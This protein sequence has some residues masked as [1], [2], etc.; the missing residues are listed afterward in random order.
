MAAPRKTK[1]YLLALG[2]VLVLVITFGYIFYRLQNNT[3]LNLTAFFEGI[4]SKGAL[5]SYYFLIFFLLATFNW[6][7]EVLKWKSLA[8]TLEKL[9]FK[10]ALKQTLA[11]L[12]VS[13]AT[14]NRIG[15]YGAKALFFHREKRKKVLLLNFYSNGIQLLTTVIF[16]VLGLFH[17]LLN[18]N[19]LYSSTALIYL[20]IGVSIFLIVMY[21]F[22][23]KELLMKGFSISNVF[24]FFKRFPNS[25]KANVVLFSICR[26]LIFSSMFYGLLLFF[27]AELSILNGM[28]LI[29]SMYLLVSVIPTIFILDVVVKGG[30][31]VWLFSF[32]GISDLTVLSTVLIMWILN[33]VLPSIIGSYFVLFYQPVTQ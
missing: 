5:A 15:E 4:I 7:F 31:A 17:F 20:A 13:L 29:F 6:I 1:Q 30:V 16:G 23:E 22:K 19:V 32:A 27:G 11:S 10:T 8:S 25:I 18:Y 21:Y 3:D 2:K 33:Y 24:K 14:P 26:Y 9:N 28:S 12:T